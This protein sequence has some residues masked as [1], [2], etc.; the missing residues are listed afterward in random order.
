M[1][2]LLIL[3]EILAG[4]AV[5]IFVVTQVLF[6]IFNG[7]PTF[8]I[9]R[10]RKENEQL[11]EMSGEIEKEQLRIEIEK[12]TRELDELHKRHN[13]PNATPKEGNGNGN[14]NAS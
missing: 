7:T 3:L 13:I 11:I 10:M 2:Q 9:F 1:I 8:P 6:P 4:V 14:V 12:L 5:V